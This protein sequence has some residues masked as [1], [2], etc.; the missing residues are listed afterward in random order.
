MLNKIKKTMEN[1]Q[2]P[3]FPKAQLASWRPKSL[4]TMNVNGVRFVGTRVG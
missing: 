4:L 3:Q 1:P 2:N